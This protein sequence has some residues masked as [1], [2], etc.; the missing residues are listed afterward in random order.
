M[1]VIAGTVLF[2]I[3]LSA[4]VYF[5]AIFTNFVSYNSTTFGIAKANLSITSSI[6]NYIATSTS[7]FLSVVQTM[8]YSVVLIWYASSTLVNSHTV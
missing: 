6:S 7:I 4:G 5:I 1:W 3:I 2:S 8:I